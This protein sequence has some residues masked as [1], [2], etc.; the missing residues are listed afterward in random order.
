MPETT[1]KIAAQ[2][3]IEVPTYE[4]IQN[5]GGL[6]AGKKV[7]T[8]TPLFSRID[9]EKLIEELEAAHKAQLEAE[10]AEE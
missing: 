10:K 5:F 4:S 2:L 6:A 3:G 9:K 7:G 1:D 8:A